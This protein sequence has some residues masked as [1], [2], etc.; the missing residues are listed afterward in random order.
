MM[1]QP[2]PTYHRQ[3]FLLFLLEQVGHVSSTD[4]QQLLFLSH[5]EISLSYYDAVRY[6]DNYHSFQAISDLEVL[7]QKGWIRVSKNTIFLKDLPYLGDGA[8]KEERW[9][10]SRWIRAYKDLAGENLTQLVNERYPSKVL[11]NRSKKNKELFTIGY[12]GISLERYLT[13]LI[14]NDVNVLYDLRRNPLSRK[15]GFSK[16]FL[17]DILPKF[18]I[19]YRHIPELGIISQKRQNLNSASDYVEL[20]DEYR[21]SLPEK[22]IY[23]QELIATL[24]DGKRIALT[25]FEEMPKSC[26]R[27]CVSEYLSNHLSV[28]VA[29]L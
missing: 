26:H 24:Y 27:Q 12:E 13:K 10:I 18:G 8:K 3:R 23:L 4:F 11:Q 1:N 7:E 19:E 28:G 20:F 9:L 17:S 29:H 22:K 5:Q 21:E 25:C 6:G 16:G 14:E 2:A 15:F